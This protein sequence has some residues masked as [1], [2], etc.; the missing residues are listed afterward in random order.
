VTESEIQKAVFA[1]LRQRGA[2]GIVYWHTPNDPSSRRKVGYRPGVA[3]VC[4]VHDGKFFALELKTEKGRPDEDQLKFR[5][6]I[7]NAGGFA[8]VV[9]GIERALGCLQA[10]GVLR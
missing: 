2:P 10:W 8:M 4:V 5:D 3:D 7:N 6:Q 1:H 9:H